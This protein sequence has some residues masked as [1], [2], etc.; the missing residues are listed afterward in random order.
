MYRSATLR[1]GCQ[2]HPGTHY[3]ACVYLAGDWTRERDGA[4]ERIDL[5]WTLGWGAGMYEEQSEC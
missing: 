1:T 2:G 3:T 5:Y 4:S